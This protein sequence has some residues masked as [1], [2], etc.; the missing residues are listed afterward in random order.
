VDA[1]PASWKVVE[2]G[3]AVVASDGEELGHIDEVVGDPESDI[4]NGITVSP[5][6]LL[7]RARYVPAEQVGEI[8]EGEVR[9]K[10]DRSGFDHLAEYDEPPP[11]EQFLAP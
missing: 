5:R 1:D 11:G 9:V 4:F 6:G 7:A 2:R 3:W 10:F 8:V